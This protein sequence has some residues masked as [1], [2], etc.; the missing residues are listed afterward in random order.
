MAALEPLRD[1][2]IKRVWAV[3]FYPRLHGGCIWKVGSDHNWIF[4]AHGF[5]QCVRFFGKA[6]SVERKHFDFSRMTCDGVQENHILSP[7]A[8]RKRNWGL[9]SFDFF[10]I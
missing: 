1:A 6:S 3:L 2:L 9:V 4:I 8:A 5:V 10:Q 7:K